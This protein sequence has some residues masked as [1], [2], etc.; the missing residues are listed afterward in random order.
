MEHDNLQRVF[1]LG[2]VGAV[3]A[4]AMLVLWV[5]GLRHGRSV[6]WARLA[7]AISFGLSSLSAGWLA[8]Q[9]HEKCNRNVARTLCDSPIDLLRSR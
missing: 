1:V 8:Y 7:F 5:R 6:A 2:G 3:V 9:R 4:L